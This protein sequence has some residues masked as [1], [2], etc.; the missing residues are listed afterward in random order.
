M[1]N[2]LLVFGGVS[3]EHDI[4]IVTAFQIYKKSRLLDYNLILFYVSRDGKYYICDEKK[5]T[6]SDFSKLK[7]DN[8][9]KGFKEVVFVSGEKQKLFT[10]TRFG[11]KE[12]VSA[13]VAVFACHGGNGENGKL[14]TLFESMNIAC[15]AGSSDAL[16]ICMDKFLFK[17]VAKGL[18]IPV[19]AG[20]K[21]SKDEY[22]NNKDLVS[23]RLGML[24]FPVVIKINSGG[25][26]IGLFTAKDEEEFDIKIKESF[27]FNDDLIV[28]KF[29]ENTR[30]FNVAVL[31]DSRNY[32]VSEIDEPIKKNDVLTFADKYL[33]ETGNKTGS[34]NSKGSM[35][36]SVRRSPDDLT[37][38]QISKIKGLAEKLFLKLGLHGVVRIDFLFDEDKNKIYVCEVNAIPGSLAFYFFKKNRIVVNDLIEKLIKIAERN[39][40]K[41]YINNEFVIDILS[42][43]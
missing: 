27:E 43:K 5:L 33:S 17:S 15:S 39:I 24:K 30:E 40:G 16:A 10:K 21:L 36:L 23:R 25:S 31:G 3:Y 38:S 19:V 34:K 9:N 12:Y 29:I 32:E 41:N 26:S 8:K 20:F 4:S 14:V 22:L 11:L 2:V 37:E 28:E 13:D 42:K 7:F 6:I 1:K 35:E 18:R